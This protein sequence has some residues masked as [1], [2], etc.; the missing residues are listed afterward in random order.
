MVELVAIAA[1]L[2][3]QR[4][5]LEKDLEDTSSRGAQTAELVRKIEDLRRRAEET[6]RRF[7]SAG[8]NSTT[9]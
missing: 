9:K 1:L 6:Q 4:Q 5:D 8:S 3:R 2:K 7:P